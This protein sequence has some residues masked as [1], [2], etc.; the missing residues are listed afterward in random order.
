MEINDFLRDKIDCQDYQQWN[1]HGVVQMPDDGDEI[2]D[3]I[4]RKK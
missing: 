3:Q 2:G 1:Y 4:E